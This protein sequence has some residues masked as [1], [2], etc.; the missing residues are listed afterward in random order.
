M[1]K[2]ILYA[3]PSGAL[4]AELGSFWAQSKKNPKLSN[5][6]H[7]YP[8]HC[9]L[10]GFFS[11]QSKDFTKKLVSALKKSVAETKKGKIQVQGITQSG[12]FHYIGLNSKYLSKVTD[13]FIANAKTQVIRKKASS[14]YHITLAHKFDSKAKK[15]LKKLEK[16]IDTSKSASWSICL[17]KKEHNTLSVVK[18]IRV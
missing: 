2:Y 14:K 15:G 4:G 9:S 6:A 11:G 10:T 3:R 12:N 16:N 7:A 13:K 1:T 18:K 17:Y 5:E 8:P